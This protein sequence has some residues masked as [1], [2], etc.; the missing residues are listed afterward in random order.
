MSEIVFAAYKPHEGKVSELEKLISRHTP[1]LR[2][3]ELVT[4]RPAL[5]I[6]SKDG[7]YIEVIEW[8]NEKTAKMAHEHPAVAKIWEAMAQIS[9]FKTLSS[10]PEASHSFA[11]Y[12]VVK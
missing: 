4:D 7:T 5:T 10:L 9:D 11:H 3:L 1:L 8:Q 2:E 12:E 6:K